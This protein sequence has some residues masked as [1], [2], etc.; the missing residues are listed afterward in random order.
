[1][2]KV[3]IGE[4]GASTRTAELD[5]RGPYLVVIDPH[6]HHIHDG[7]NFDA[8]FDVTGTSLIVAFKVEDQSKIPHFIFKWKTENDATFT[9]YK[10]ATWDTSSGT[11][12]V[13]LNCDHSSS[14]TSILQS[15]VTGSFVSNGIIL[16]PTNLSVVS[17]TT[18]F[19]ESAWASAANPSAEGSGTREER[20]LLPGETY[21]IEI[22]A[23]SGGI[24]LHLDWYEEENH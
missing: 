1:M 23:T 20:L 19:A 13:P 16:N 14:N 21:A 4:T 8:T 11:T 5:A 12:R 6:H 22:A 9:F 24:W 2:E 3:L 18:L 10:G 17:A 15:D 7:V